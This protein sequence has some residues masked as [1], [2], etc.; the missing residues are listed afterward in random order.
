MTIN[1]LELPPEL[2]ALRPVEPRDAA[3]L[4]VVDGEKRADKKDGATSE[5]GKVESSA[6]PRTSERARG[7]LS[8]LVRPLIFRVTGQRRL[9]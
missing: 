7:E 3:R 6:I 5:I 2:I 8:W 1:G 4:L 9:R